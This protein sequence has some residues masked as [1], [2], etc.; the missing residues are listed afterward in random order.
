ME[1]PYVSLHGLL[2]FVLQNPDEV[3]QNPDEVVFKEPE[4][5][6]G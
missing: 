5:I 6:E 2:R 4:L 3:V 1:D